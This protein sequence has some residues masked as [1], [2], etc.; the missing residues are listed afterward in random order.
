MN[1]S[2]EI[3]KGM[4]GNL[5]KKFNLNSLGITALVILFSFDYYFMMWYNALKCG[6]LWKF[7]S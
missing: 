7:V 4:R 1:L 2:G 5:I 3:N 6:G